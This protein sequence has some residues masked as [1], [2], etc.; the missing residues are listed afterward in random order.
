MDKAI[1]RNEIKYKAVRASGAGGQHVNKVSTKVELS[2]D[3]AKTNAFTIEEK[4]RLL[5]KLSNKLNKEDIL[6]IQSQD[7]RSQLK[8]KKDAEDK[9]LKVLS[10][11]LFVPKKRKKTLPSKKMKENRL[12]SKKIQS[13]KKANRSRIKLD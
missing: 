10:A 9:L 2:F 12:R 4:I 6:I 5:E 11:A 7:S 13:D 3:L 8:N 1:I